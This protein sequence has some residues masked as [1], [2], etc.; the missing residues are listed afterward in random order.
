MTPGLTFLGPLLL[1]IFILTFGPCNESFFKIPLQDHL[2]AF[3]NRTIHE[4]LLT[5]ITLSKTLTLHKSPWSTFQAFSSHPRDAPIPQEAVTENWPL[6][7]I[8]NQ[9]TGMAEST[10]GLMVEMAHYVD[11][12]MKNKNHSDP[13]D[14]PDCPN[15]IL[16]S[17]WRHLQGY[18]TTRLRPP[19]TW[20]QDS[21][22]LYQPSL[23]RIFIMGTGK[24][25]SEK[26]DTSSLLRASH[27]IV[28]LIN[29]LFFAWLPGLLSLHTC[30][31]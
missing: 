9:K 3:T 16:F 2:W 20:A 29:S 18:K 10:W 14:W 12:T 23:Q 21:T 6:A 15:D 26:E 4:L 17:C 1:L 11:L 7:L 13:W 19:A 24:A 31:Q 22:R 8:P 25:P 30:L 28:S 27:P 5:Q